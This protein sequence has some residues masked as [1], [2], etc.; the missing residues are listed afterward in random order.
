MSRVLFTFMCLLWSPIFLIGGIVYLI[1]IYR[2]RGKVS[3]TTYEPF[4][5]RLLYELLGRRPDPAARKL[6]PKLPAT[7][8]LVLATLYYPIAWIVRLSG[9]Q[10]DA[11]NYPL[12]EFREF[13]HSMAA[14]TQF[15]DGALEEF[16]G[17]GDQVVILGAGWDTRCYS[18]LRDKQASLFEVDAP[19][20]Q[21]VK[22]RGLER[23]GIDIRGVSFVPCDFNEQDWLAALESSG[24]SPGR[25]TIIVWEGVTM[26]LPEAVIEKTLA[27]VASLAAGSRLVCDVFVEEWIQNT[28]VGRAAAKTFAFQYGEEWIYGI[29][30]RPDVP[31]VLRGLLTSCGLELERCLV[32]GEKQEIPPVALLLALNR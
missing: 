10:P 9:F 18:L 4:S 27:H 26:Y 30:H 25:R 11:L 15:I 17:A 22:R 28:R 21:A 14:R 12:Q 29:D 3:G 8:P 6:A 23:A 7:N 20:T 32:V 13:R 16:V 1:P 19:A 24:F 31:A 5:I 2:S